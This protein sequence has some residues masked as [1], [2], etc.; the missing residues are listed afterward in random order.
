VLAYGLL[1]MR[2]VYAQSW[3]VTVLK[4]VLLQASFSVLELIGV[5]GAGLGGFIFV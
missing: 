1:A 2:R 3:G 4:F 5:L